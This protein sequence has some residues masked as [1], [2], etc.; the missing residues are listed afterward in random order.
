MKA[1][2]IGLSL[3]LAVALAAPASAQQLRMMTGPQG[4]SWIPIGGQLKDLWEKAIP[5]TNVQVF[6]G[7]GALQVGE[8]PAWQ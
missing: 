3:G 5:G 1:K 6:P 4:G 2:M 8:A 7:A